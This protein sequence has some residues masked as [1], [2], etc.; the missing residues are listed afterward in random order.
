MRRSKALRKGGFGMA[1]RA[2]GFVGKRA[3]TAAVANPIGIAVGA[4]VAGAVIA[5]AVTLRLASGRS[6]ENMGEQVNKM[7]LGDLDDEG[8]ARMTTRR[9]LQGDSDLAR[10]N[11]ASGGENAQIQKLSQDL[12]EL[13][14]REE[15][16]ASLV[17]EDER[18]QSNG[19]FDMLILRAQQVFLHFWNSNGGPDG[20]ERVRDRLQENYQR[21]HRNQSPR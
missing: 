15:K 16:G 6:F 14:K 17:R 11:A 1:T 2:A 21:R 3:A 4:L 20:V 9:Y 7:L 18:F 10:I 5:G 13:N 8:R 19:V 12:F